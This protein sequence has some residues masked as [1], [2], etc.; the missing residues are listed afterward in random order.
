[1]APRTAEA[2]SAYLA[3]SP[4]GERQSHVAV[5]PA[6]PDKG[7]V[8]LRRGRE[9]SFATFSGPAPQAVALRSERGIEF[10]S[11]SRQRE[12]EDG[13][14]DQRQLGRKRR[15]FPKRGFGLM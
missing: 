10:A 3:P 11:R 4:Y 5:E 14:K 6:M 13:R 2:S 1:M 8:A 9:Q 12:P 15:R 7:D